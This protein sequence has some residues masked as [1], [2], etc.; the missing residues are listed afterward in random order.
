M[1]SPA[2]APAQELSFGVT[3][4][5]GDPVVVTP[6]EPL[7]QVGRVAETA[8][9]VWLETCRFAAWP[10]TAVPAASTAAV[11]RNRIR[12]CRLRIF[13]HLGKCQRALRLRPQTRW[14]SEARLSAAQD[15]RHAGHP[16]R[17]RGG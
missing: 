2:V 8:P 10:T 12:I 5:M 3:L 4:V 11:A 7:A 14:R 17:A 16:G 13:H 6:I 1:R 15:D 9:S